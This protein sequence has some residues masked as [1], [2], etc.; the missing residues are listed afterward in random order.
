MDIELI[1][2]NGSRSIDIDPIIKRYQHDIARSVMAEFMMLGGGSTGSY[3]L[4]KSKTDLFL[5]SMESYINTIVDVLNRQL[6]ERLWMLNGLPWETMPKLVAGDVAP[7][8]IAEI[9]SLL[10]NLN[11]ADVPIAMHGEVVEDIMQIAEINFDANKYEENL[12]K[13]QEA[14]QM[15]PASPNRG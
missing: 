13:K 5:R 9:S 12:R 7:H 2:S 4:S 1:T 8:D 3:A 11:G 10:R 14:D 6:I 15:E